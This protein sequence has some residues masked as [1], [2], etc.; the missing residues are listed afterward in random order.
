MRSFIGSLLGTGRSLE[1]CVDS[2]QKD[3]SVVFLVVSFGWLKMRL[4]TFS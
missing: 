4:A 2:V 3:V 1:R